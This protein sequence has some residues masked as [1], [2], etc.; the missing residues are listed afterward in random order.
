M[1]RINGI[2][3]SSTSQ[4]LIYQVMIDILQ[5]DGDLGTRIHVVCQQCMVLQF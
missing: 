3:S 5:S 4:V 1:S 2:E